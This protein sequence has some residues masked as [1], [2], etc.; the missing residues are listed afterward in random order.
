VA[1]SSARPAADRRTLDRIDQETA[2]RIYRERFANAGDFTFAFV[3]AFDPD[4]IRP[5][6][7]Q[8]LASLPTT[9]RVDTPRDN[10]MRPVRGVVEKVVRKGLEQKSQTRITFTGPFEYTREN[11][12]AIT[13]MV[14]ILDM[15]LRDVLR[16]DLGGTYGVGISQNTTRFPDGRYTVSV[17]FGSA[18]DRLD[19]LA[20]A[21]FAEIEKL[22]A[23]GP[24]AAAFAKMKEQQ[25]R[26]YE[27]SLQRNE[28]WTS[29]LM[30]EAETGE[31]AAGALDLVQRLDALTPAQIQQAARLYLDTANYVR[32]SLLPQAP[33]S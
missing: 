33:T 28:F 10:G 16:E 23:E 21:V 13:A 19:E 12:L 2:F 11:R 20:A 18:P 30:R 4:E 8:Y 29:V 17:A 5:L 25:R 1:E 24:D 9:D 26:G 27:T 14:D 31:R 7:E 3:G 32:V 15:K 22:K 6:I